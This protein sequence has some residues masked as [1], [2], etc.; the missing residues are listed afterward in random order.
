[1]KPDHRTGPWPVCLAI[2]MI[3]SA[4]AIAGCVDSPQEPQKPAPS[5]G[6]V[7]AVRSAGGTTIPTTMIPEST[8]R[9]PAQPAS[10]PVSSTGVI[11]IDPISDK[12]AGEK[13]TLTGKTSL[14]PG[15]NIIWQI[16]PDTGT[17]PTGLDKDS[18]MSVGGNYLVTKGDGTANRLSLDVDLGRLIP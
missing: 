18:M 6:D 11:Q 17:P 7:S 10:L 3:L 16:L 5:P 12:T 13:F 2:L 15:T 9:T 8:T 1:M 14:P 4:I